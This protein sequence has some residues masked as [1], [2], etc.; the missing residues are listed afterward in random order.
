MLELA[1]SV[2]VGVLHVH[3]EP[4]HDSHAPFERV[5]EAAHATELDFVVLTEHAPASV[6]SGPLPA[7]EHAGRYT[8]PRDPTD[9]PGRELLVLVGVE[10]GTRDGHLLAYALD[11]LV[12]AA[13]RSG[14]DVIAD[15]HAAG[16]FAV[17]PHPFSHGGWR[18]WDAPFDGIEVHNNASAIRRVP[19]WSLA[20]QYS[21]AMFDPAASLRAVLTRDARA[22][23]QW[24]DLLGAGRRVIGFSGADAH[25]GVRVLGRRLDPYEVFMGAVQ[26]HCPVPERTAAALWQA[27]RRGECWIHYAVREE[28]R[29]EAKPVGFPSGRSELQLDAGKHVLELRNPI[30]AGDVQSRSPE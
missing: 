12:P 8:D 1:A 25:E 11:E 10:F 4:S 23:A 2:L 13:G 27:L 14:R 29:A 17:V 28:R 15:I 30:L 9:R 7:A 24:D 26:T 6:T 5:L 18:A 21:R 3:H 19:G 22:L 16:G 20:W